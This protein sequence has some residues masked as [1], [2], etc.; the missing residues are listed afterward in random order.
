MNINLPEQSRTN[1]RTETPT[2]FCPSTPGDV[3]PT[4]TLLSQK[5]ERFAKGIKV[6]KHDHRTYLT[7]FGALHVKIYE[8][9]EQRRP[10]LKLFSVPLIPVVVCLLFLFVGV[11]QKKAKLLYPFIAFQ[12]FVAFVTAI[13]MGMIAI[14]VACNTKYIL[15]LIVDVTSDEAIY[16]SSAL[17]ILTVLSLS[18]FVQIWYL[19]TVCTCFR[20]FTDLQRFK[21]DNEALVF[22]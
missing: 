20:Y 15:R 10:N 22:V 17:K 8:G 14:S 9:E 5:R 18:L 3:S 7:C 6:F 19:R 13:S 21:D 11:L 1:T 12:V 16:R 2:D 4:N